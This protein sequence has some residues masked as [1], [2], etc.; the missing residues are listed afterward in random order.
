LNRLRAETALSGMGEG[1][2]FDELG[3]HFHISASAPADNK[4]SIEPAK[5]IG[6]TRLRSQ[7]GHRLRLAIGHLL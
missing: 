1:M 6:C 7:L 3:V 2:L 5:G 4:G